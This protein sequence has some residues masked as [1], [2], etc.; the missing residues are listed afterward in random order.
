MKKHFWPKVPEVPFSHGM[1]HIYMCRRSV[2]VA[3]YRIVSKCFYALLFRRPRGEKYRTAM[4]HSL[5]RSPTMLKHSSSNMYGENYRVKARAMYGCP[6]VKARAMYMRIHA[7]KSARVSY[8]LLIV[9]GSV[10]RESAWFT[11]LVRLFMITLFTFIRHMTRPHV[12]NPA[13]RG[14]VLPY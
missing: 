6:R 12:L 4:L 7:A 11:V 5:S 2:R 8:R 10:S 13:A 3:G 9:H 1:S 14:V